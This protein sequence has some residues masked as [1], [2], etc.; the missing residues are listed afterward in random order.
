M[1]HSPLVILLALIPSALGHAPSHSPAPGHRPQK[2]SPHILSMILVFVGIIIATDSCQ[3]PMNVNAGPPLS[4]GN[5]Q[6]AF[7]LFKKV[8]TADK[9]TN[10]FFSPL[11]IS[12]ALAMPY[13]GSE[14]ATRT[15][16]AQVLH[17]DGPQQEVASGFH[18][19][20][21]G[22]T[23]PGETAYQLR[24]ANALWAAEGEHFEPKFVSLMH[25]YYSG[26]FR[27][28]NF[29][30]TEQ[31][32]AEINHW[33]AEKTAGKIQ[34]LLHPGDTTPLTR[35][36]LT[37]AIYFK[38]DWSYPF[39]EKFTD[40]AAFTTSNGAKKQ[41]PMMHQ[42]YRFRYTETDKLQALELPYAGDQLSM[43][44][45]LPR[46]GARDPW[47]DLIA[48]KIQQLRLKMQSTEVEVFL[49]RFKVEAR[50]SLG[51][52]LSGMGMPDA[53]DPNAADFSGITGKKDLF[54]SKVLH[55][56][57]VEVNEK[58][59]EAAA[60]T[61]VVVAPKAMPG[62][63]VAPPVF[64]ADHPFFYMITYKSSDSLLFMGRLSDPPH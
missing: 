13:A 34:Q 56:A 7:D 48:E 31:S 64:R 38:G 18:S 2:P 19:V 11:S 32:R 27:T 44:I 60:A 59:T 49:P 21:A 46:A 57:V 15:Q 53:F 29:A 33:V 4:I 20:M 23:K 1:R 24:V 25:T 28:V 62:R 61:A 63:R 52:T 6:F 3:K 16:M 43:L 45:L 58:G 41:V 42:T 26:D 5:N 37:N 14:G 17:F 8:G 30:N 35:L 10:V 40:P 22:M 12:A 9:D 55:Q 54:I 51:P 36:V 47:S 39:N 50:L